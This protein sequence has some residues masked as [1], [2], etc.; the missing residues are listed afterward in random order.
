MWRQEIT[1]EQY[2][3]L[4][5]YEETSGTGLILYAMGVGVRTGVLDQKKYLPVFRRGIEGLKKVS[6]GENFETC[7]SCPACRCPEDGSIHAYLS[8][9]PSYVDEPHGA[10][11]VIMALAE[12]HRCGLT[13]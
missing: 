9:A 2:Q 1:V 4:D 3:G 13:D 10:G 8:Q 7:H 11:P 5:S 6:I 12:A